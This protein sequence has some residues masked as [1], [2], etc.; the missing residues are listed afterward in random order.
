LAARIAARRW[1]GRQRALARSAW[2]VPLMT[3]SQAG[4]VLDARAKHACGSDVDCTSGRVCI[5]RTCQ[6]RSD[7]G[8]TAGCAPGPVDPAQVG[9]TAAPPGRGNYVFVTSQCYDPAFGSLE[10]ADEYCSSAASSAGLPGTYRAW[11]SSGLVSTNPPVAARERLEGARGWIRRDGAP[12]A[13]TIVD[14]VGGRIFFPPLLDEYGRE[15]RGGPPVATGTSPDGRMAGNCNDWT[16]IPVSADLID[17]PRVTVGDPQGTMADWTSHGDQILCDQ[18][19]RLYC[20]GIDENRQVAVAPRIGRKAFLSDEPFRSAGLKG[21]DDLCNQEAMTEGI[22]GHFVALLA[23]SQT[24]AA[25][26]IDGAAVQW[27]RLDGVPLN[28]PGENLF[29]TGP[30]VA[31]LNLTSRML[32]LSAGVFTGAA[33]AWHPGTLETTCQDWTNNFLKE[34]TTLGISSHGPSWFT[35]I[36]GN[37]ERGF[38]RVYCLESGSVAP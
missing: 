36:P 5:Q 22:A 1:R 17:L 21:A 31:P 24:A 29:A 3:A 20:F 11:L 15:V 18:P 7:A 16:R 12:F 32:Y 27:V 6:D 35:G 2:I 37:C 9:A 4:C 34:Y 10:V 26:R 38:G 19:L 14:I 30:T 28:K 25:D 23:D 8:F 33:D 13:D